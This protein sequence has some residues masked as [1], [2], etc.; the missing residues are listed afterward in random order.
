MLSIKIKDG[1]ASVSVHGV[2]LPEISSLEISCAD[3]SSRVALEIINGDVTIEHEDEQ[4]RRVASLD[5]L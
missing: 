1:K 3:G 4:D 5:T 2:S